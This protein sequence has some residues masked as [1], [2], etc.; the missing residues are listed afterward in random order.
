MTNNE[1]YIRGFEKAAS[2]HGFNPAD[3]MRFAEHIEK[4]AQMK[5][6]VNSAFKFLTKNPVP[7][8][9]RAWV[10]VAGDG[11]KPLSSHIKRYLSLLKGD[12]PELL[13][14]KGN[15]SYYKELLK[16]FKTRSGDPMGELGAVRNMWRSSNGDVNSE[17]KKILA[18]RLGTAGILGAT[19]YGLSD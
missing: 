3:L 16:Q 7:A 14:A 1:A 2:E 9:N 15:R 18:A 17:L 4:K 13:K 19:A 10:Y 6:V 12:T 8:I 5:G 11:A